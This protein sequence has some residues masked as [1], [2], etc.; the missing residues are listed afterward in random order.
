MG[1]VVGRELKPVPESLVTNGKF[2]FGTFN[3]QFQKVNPLDA[4]RP[5]GIPLP[6][7]L[8]SFRL[9]EWQAF[10]LGNKR[11]FMLAVLYNAK[12]SALAQFIAYDKETKKK[13]VFDK[14]LPS[15]EIKVPGSLWDA[16]SATA[17][18]IISLR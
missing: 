5:L 6:K 8:L 15:W 1:E 12:F 18:R 16:N 9:K 7:S 17:T 11:W 10:Q 2:N 13:Y 3:S 4:V 14:M